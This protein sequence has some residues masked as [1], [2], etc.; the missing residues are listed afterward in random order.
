M[1]DSPKPIVLLL[2]EVLHAKKE[3]DRLAE[4]AE[5]RQLNDGNREQ[6]LSDCNSGVYH[7]LL[8][9]SRTYDSV[10]LTGRFDQELIDLLPQT[11]KFI[12][13]NGAGYDQID[14]EACA[15]RGISVSNTP[16]AVDASTANTAIYLLLGAL[17]RAHIPATALRQGRWRG[18][19]GLGHDP[20]GKMLG[21]L[22]MGGIGSA[23]AL[24]AA[25]FGFDMQYHNRNP[26]VHP[27]SNPT[28]ARYVGFEEL[29]RTSDV[30]S[31]HLPLNDTTKGLIGREEFEKMKDGVVIVNTAR[32]K[33]VDEEALVEALEQDKVFAAGLDVYEKEPDVHPGLIESDKVVL[34]PH[35]GTATVETQRKMEILVIDNVRN[36]L[37]H[38]S[39]LT[40][41]VESRNYKITLISVPDFIHLVT[42]T[43][44]PFLCSQSSPSCEGSLSA[45][46]AHLQFS[47]MLHL[48]VAGATLVVLAI[49]GAFNSENVLRTIAAGVGNTFST[50]TDW[51]NPFTKTSW[52]ELADASVGLF[53]DHVWP[54]L[55]PGSTG[56]G[57]PYVVSFADLGNVTTFNATANIP[58]PAVHIHVFRQS[59][60]EVQIIWGILLTLLGGFFVLVWGTVF[61]RSHSTK[62]RRT[63]SELEVTTAELHKQVS[64]NTP[65]LGFLEKLFSMTKLNDL[66]AMREPLRRLSTE[67]RAAPQTP[68]LPSISKLHLFAKPKQ[69][70]HKADHASVQSRN[71]LEAKVKEYDEL[72][73][74]GDEL[75]I[76]LNEKIRQLESSDRKVEETAISRKQVQNALDSTTA[77]YNKVCGQ[78]TEVKK[79]LRNANALI[80]DLR[81]ASQKMDESYKAK[82]KEHDAALKC[83]RLQE[84]TSAELENKLATAN[85]Q[86]QMAND[87][88]HAF[89]NGPSNVDDAL[90]TPLPG[91]VNG[92]LEDPRK[93]VTSL[94]KPNQ[95]SSSTHAPS[96][97][98]LDPATPNLEPVRNPQSSQPGSPTQWRTEEQAKEVHDQLIALQRAQ[99]IDPTNGP[100]DAANADTL[101]TGDQR[102][103]T[104]SSDALHNSAATSTPVSQGADSSIDGQDDTR[105]RSTTPSQSPVSS[106]A[107]VP[108]R[109]RGSPLRTNM[110]DI[111][112][113]ARKARTAGPTNGLGEAPVSP[114]DGFRRAQGSAPS[115]RGGYT[116][117]AESGRG[118]GSA[119]SARGGRGS[120]YNPWVDPNFYDARFPHYFQGGSNA[121]P[122]GR[123]GR[124][125]NPNRGRQTG[126]RAELPAFLRAQYDENGVFKPES[127][128]AS[129]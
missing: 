27:S 77:E 8:A 91:P 36:V 49:L 90:N 103:G 32:G 40:P 106:T 65:A 31:I 46:L 94:N 21:I 116:P 75:R 112:E 92:E 16:G 48:V 123:G 66:T 53:A 60:T 109:S 59:M 11:L 6:F 80:E 3:W 127:G 26:I 119:P 81:H 122:R 41:V 110:E 126:G 39:L 83:L 13:H 35:V 22:G 15:S 17:R 129:S 51:P 7:G 114:H 33:I 47:I 113:A 117:P 71:L 102:P 23:F 87:R 18:S 118:R 78:K 10:E 104:S 74:I 38:G 70:D 54:A 73:R 79:E 30:I 125:A 61:F 93:D 107:P 72:L 84:S 76:Q 28:N 121:S 12:S 34:M 97:P 24:R 52:I 64:R 37:E 69:E 44:L 108:N 4:I 101:P 56:T 5:L 68:Y 42:V 63:V 99:L 9:I 88:W 96:F 50:G 89:S 111:H 29:L 85:G 86:L 115:N 14:A 2:G 82:G 95:S 58:E 120:D 43:L 55:I 124:S 67:T 25:T 62:I 20:D 128:P 57:R 105:G 98:A 45:L 100:G 1:T 19:M